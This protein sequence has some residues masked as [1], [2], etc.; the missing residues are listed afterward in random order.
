VLAS[1][2]LVAAAPS[3]QLAT[4][5]GVQLAQHTAVFYTTQEIEVHFLKDPELT[6]PRMPTV[7]DALFQPK[8]CIKCAVGKQVMIGLDGFISHNGEFRTPDPLEEP[9]RRLHPDPAPAATAV[10]IERPTSVPPI[11]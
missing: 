7:Y 1:S 8:G 6:T 5:N 4:H 9:Q 3:V 2:N 10:G 11:L